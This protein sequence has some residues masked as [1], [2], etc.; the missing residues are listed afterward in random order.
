MFS[1][2]MSTLPLPHQSLENM[3]AQ[4]ALGLIMAAS[5][6][7]LLAAILAPQG[8]RSNQ[9]WAIVFGAIGMALAG[10]PFWM[11]KT[12][13]GSNIGE[14]QMKVLATLLFILLT[15]GAFAFTFGGPFIQTGNVQ[16]AIT[17]NLSKLAQAQEVHLTVR[18]LHGFILAASVVELASAGKP[19][20]HSCKGENVYAIIVGVVSICITGI[21]MLFAFFNSPLDK[22]KTEYMSWFL[23]LWWACGALILTFYGPFL[24]TGNCYFS[25]WAAF[26]F[27]AY[28]WVLV[29]GN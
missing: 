25:S 11:F 12:G 6:V 24:A 26:R 3:N 7:V 18:D 20:H 13:K 23:F 2:T 28:L 14:V 29:I 27:S 16:V 4:T 5:F 9:V 15:I 17:N 10:I 22:Q 19:C 21:A 1:S 8:Y